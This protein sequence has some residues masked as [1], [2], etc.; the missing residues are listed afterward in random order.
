MSFKLFKTL[1]ERAH[2]KKSLNANVIVNIVCIT[3]SFS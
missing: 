1:N 3:V 2:T